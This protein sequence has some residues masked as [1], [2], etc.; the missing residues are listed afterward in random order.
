MSSRRKKSAWIL[1]LIAILALI[2][3]LYRSR[4]SMPGGAD[5]GGLQ[6]GTSP[7]G[8][9]GGSSTGSPQPS[10]PQPV[11]GPD[12]VLL[13]QFRHPP[14]NNRKFGITGRVYSAG[15]SPVQG[16]TVTLYGLRNE[17]T[18]RFSNLLASAST[19]E[20]GIYE[21]KLDSPLNGYLLASSHGF[22]SSESSASFDESYP[23]RRDF[24]L[25]EGSAAVRGRVIDLQG[26][27]IEDAMVR[28][29]FGEIVNLA[30]TYRLSMPVA[31]TDSKGRYEV[32]SVPEGRR[33]VFAF[34]EDYGYVE[35]KEIDVRSGETCEIDFR[36]PRANVVLARVVDA[37]RRPIESARVTWGSGP[38][39][40]GI[41]LSGG[42]GFV[43]VRAGAGRSS[44]PI[45]CQI[46][47]VGYL[48]RTAVIDPGQQETEI[49]LT[50]ADALIGMVTTPDGRPIA[51]ARIQVRTRGAFETGLSDDSGGF[52]IAVA[53]P[54][55]T[56][57][58][59]SKPGYVTAS[60]LLDPKLVPGFQRITLKPAEIGG[61]IYGKIVTSAGQPV[62]TFSI[63][64]SPGSERRDFSSLDGEFEVT[65]LPEG[66]Y[67]FVV[68]SQE[69]KLNLQAKLDRIE[70]R[71]GMAY[72]PVVIRLQEPVR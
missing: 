60:F 20:S 57:V 61:G 38:E 47:A 50:R 21:I 18:R 62:Y 23:L 63:I 64:I 30:R 67:S 32:S 49:I 24:V 13:D 52:A 42:D 41:A 39:D 70:V 7:T 51:R 53:E 8:L 25:E 16:A 31:I 27:P 55:A 5:Q 54:P 34:H 59:A 46:Q 26:N 3:F 37:A 2:G 66:N 19:N 43:K 33:S 58:Q 48:T 22:A 65:D 72:G 4:G 36:L 11:A 44:E 17:V 28:V 12:Y 9:A 68:H 71:K 29:S 6:H 35:G 69:G 1:A 40:G 14:D 56:E 15:H 45:R 10:I